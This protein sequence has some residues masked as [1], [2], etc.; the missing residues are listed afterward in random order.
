M[1]I[2]TKVG[3]VALAIL[4]AAAAVPAIAV[5]RPFD[6]GL[7]QSDS[8]CDGKASYGYK[9]TWRGGPSAGFQVN[10]G[11]QCHLSG[12]VC[13]ISNKDCNVTCNASGQC[14]TAVSACTQ[15]HGATW[16]QI[17]AKDGSGVQRI[18]TPNGERCT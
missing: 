5:I 16:A 2:R 14:T 6:F 4:V 18:V 1:N 12:A 10:S 3:I 7:K 15:G 8:R 17:V 9:L 13:G 11:N